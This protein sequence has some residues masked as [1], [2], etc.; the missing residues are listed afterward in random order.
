M[1]KMLTLLF[2]LGAITTVFAQ[3]D[4]R[5]ESRDVILGQNRTVYQDDRRV[6][7]GIR[8]RDEQ[9]RQINWRFDN[10]IASL[11]HNRYLRHGDRKRQIRVLEA[12]RKEEIR[13]VNLRFAQRNST[14]IYRN[15]RY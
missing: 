12:Q 15:G 1:K 9:I 13:L 3:Y 10:A 5:T 7:F 14:H 4:H 2:A 11:E 8:E 6:V